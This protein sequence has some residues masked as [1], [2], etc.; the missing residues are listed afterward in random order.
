MKEQVG[1]SETLRCTNGAFIVVLCRYLD[2]VKCKWSIKVKYFK[3]MR[4]GE[5][6]ATV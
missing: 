6:V 2:K 4:N 1:Y 5:G 3:I